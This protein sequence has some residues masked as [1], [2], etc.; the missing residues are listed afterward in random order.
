LV[1][2]FRGRKYEEIHSL[3]TSLSGNRIEVRDASLTCSHYMNDGVDFGLHPIQTGKT[4]N[5]GVQLDDQI[6][7]N[8]TKH[9]DRRHFHEAP[10]SRIPISVS[11]SVR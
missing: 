7:G 6:L 4:G 5:L 3:G 9:I 8:L 1:G 10:F 2:R 11:A